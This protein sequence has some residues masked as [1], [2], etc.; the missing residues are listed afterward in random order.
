MQSRPGDLAQVQGE[1]VQGLEGLDHGG[2]ARS[3]GS[4]GEKRPGRRVKFSSNGAE[5]T[6]CLLVASPRPDP[7]NSSS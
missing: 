4:R 2:V 1:G 3:E 7:R 6:D 5:L